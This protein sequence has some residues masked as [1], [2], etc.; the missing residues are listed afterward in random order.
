MTR[1]H[2]EWVKAINFDA[3][4]ITKERTDLRIEEEG[5]QWWSPAVEDNKADE[6]DKFMNNNKLCLSFS[7]TQNVKMKWKKPKGGYF[8]VL[9]VP[10]ERDSFFLLYLQRIVF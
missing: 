4:K 7:Y 6:E 5:L 3:K 9:R 2:D 8:D 1:N 10:E